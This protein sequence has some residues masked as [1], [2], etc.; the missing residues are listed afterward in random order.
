MSATAL[1]DLQLSIG[2]DLQDLKVTIADA[3]KLLGEMGSDFEK[4][5]SAAGKHSKG[6]GKEVS[7]LGDSIRDLAREQRS[8]QR[9]GSFFARELAELAP[10]SATAKTAISGLAG[11]MMGSLGLGMAIELALT[12]WKTY[13]EREKE[14]EEQAKKVREAVNEEARAVAKLVDISNDIRLVQTADS[15]GKSIE[16]ARIKYGREYAAINAELLEADRQ[17]EEN[18]KKGN[19]SVEE[20]LR[21][22]GRIAALKE[23]KKELPDRELAVEKKINAEWDLREI[24]Q[25]NE[26]ALM[27]PMTEEQKIQAKYAAEM[28]EIHA[29][30]EKHLLDEK[31]ASFEIAKA[32]L[33]RKNALDAI[34]NR[35][36][37]ARLLNREQGFAELEAPAYPKDY[38]YHSPGRDQTL[39]DVR[40][41]G[42]PMGGEHSD[43]YQADYLGAELQSYT[44]EQHMQANE[45]QKE[46]TQNVKDTVAAYQQWGDVG[47]KAI[48]AMIMGHQSLGQTA[49]QVGQQIINATVQAAIASIQADAAAA[50]VAAG[51]SQA[52]MPLVGPVLAISAAGAMLSAMLGYMGNVGGRELG[53][54]VGYRTPYIVGEAG[55]ELF[56]PGASGNIIPNHRLGGTNIT[57]H[58]FDSQSVDR[59]ARD[60]SS[61]FRKAQR[62]DSLRRRS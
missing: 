57:I 59:M 18:K 4:F 33:E 53:G 10:V 44:A 6:A 16:E 60:Y 58:A 61:P 37:A 5:G 52:G 20:N 56:V 62:H 25:K 42:L 29:R 19:K 9:V 38:R 45:A 49:A 47:G 55:P 14:V 26:L 11:A 41:S 32:T 31:E 21:L 24:K 12:G 35:Q 22:V 17:L 1:S 39:W 36:E 34:A 2:A 3:K 46:T 51:K 23:S 27:L 30:V 13:V 48:G 8:Q 15:R 50:A 40:S 43:Q 28:A 54:P 7:G